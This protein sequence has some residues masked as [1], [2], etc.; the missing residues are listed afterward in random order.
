MIGISGI[1][2]AGKD[3]FCRLLLKEIKKQR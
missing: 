3:L 2:G 1:A